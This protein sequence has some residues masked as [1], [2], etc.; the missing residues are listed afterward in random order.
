MPKGKPKTGR[1]KWQKPEIARQKNSHLADEFAKRMAP[2][3]R[4][5][6]A[7]GAVLKNQFATWLNENG[8]KNRMR[9]PWSRVA[10]QRLFARLKKLNDSG[11]TAD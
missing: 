8:H 9:K 5:A 6:S 11:W 2:L 4:Q 1:T 3:L 7:E 10:V